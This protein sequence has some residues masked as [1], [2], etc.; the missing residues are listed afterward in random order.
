MNEIPVVFVQ[1]CQFYSLKNSDGVTVAGISRVA[2]VIFSYSLHCKSFFLLHKRVDHYF[3]IIWS[4]VSSTLDVYGKMW[5]V[6]CEFVLP[7]R[8]MVLAGCLC[9]MELVCICYCSVE[10][11]LRAAGIL[12]LFFSFWVLLCTF[13]MYLDEHFSLFYLFLSIR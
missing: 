3:W 10:G 7:H 5:N 11:G 4:M 1:C 8:V 9:L 12:L 6:V 2:T 13:F